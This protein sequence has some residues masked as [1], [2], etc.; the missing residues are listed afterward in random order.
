METLDEIRRKNLRKLAEDAG[1]V[2]ALAERIGIAQAQMSMWVNG[3]KD[4]R[5][6]KP[7]G[8]RNESIELIEEKLSLPPGWLNRDHSETAKVEIIFSEMGIKKL[9]MENG[10]FI[11]SEENIRKAAALR[12]DDDAMEPIF[13]LGDII[14][15]EQEV[16][17][18][19][20]DYVVAK[21]GDEI[22]LRTYKQKT[23]LKCEL[24]PVN[25]N[26]PILRSGEIDF[27]IIGV[28]VE[29]RRKYKRV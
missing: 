13:R 4:S 5:T 28:V 27:K 15:I 24:I 17:P 29:H 16:N 26:Y 21:T 3:S 10:K 8:I 14:I 12:V 9:E 6:G 23:P 19:P 22:I 2:T 7:R 1:G 20:G 25:T 18:K 11:T